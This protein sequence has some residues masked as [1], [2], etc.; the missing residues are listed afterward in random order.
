MGYAKKAIAGFSWQTVLKLSIY[1][2]SLIK[3]YFLARLLSPAAFGLF[4]LTAIALGISESL[5]QTGV[6]LTI[7]QSKHSVKYFLDTAW[8]IAI[9]RGLLIGII[10][11]LFGFGMTQYFAQPKLMILTATAALIPVIKGFI[12]P[13][14]VIMHKKMMF[15]QD[16][17]Y[18][19]AFLAIEILLSIAFGFWLKSAFALVFGMISSALFEVVVSFIFFKH[20]PVF[21]FLK[22]R[23]KIILNNA[24]WLSLGTLLNYLSENLDDF[25]IGRITNT[26]D[27]GIYHNAYSLTHK[28]NYQLAKSVHHGTIPI[29]TQIK[30][31]PARLKKGFFKSFF[32][33]LL[34][35]FAASL[36]I[37]LLPKLFV[38]IL[39]GNQYQAA[40]SLLRP[41]VL[42]GIIQSLT[43]ICYTLFLAV[44]KYHL[45]NL[46]LFI[47][48]VLMS[49]FIFFWGTQSGLNGAVNGL[50]WARIISAP[51][52]FWGV[53]NYFNKATT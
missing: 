10:M 21:R 1:V 24:K 40:T 28:A 53:I 35:V 51:I 3:I 11:L 23:G 45:L 43:T 14:V 34:I 17:L 20:R 36:P 16:S 48:L 37:L 44:K 12:N 6:N 22:S 42:A 30:H 41:L 46:H 18:R 50:L 39:L 7:I 47:S 8:V 31:Q 5:T 19:F 9:A 38:D 2:L 29:L 25:L 52:A 4:S 27:L 33:T 49:L 26:Y 13:Y 32:A 15:F